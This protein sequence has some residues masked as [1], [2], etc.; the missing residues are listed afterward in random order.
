M[1]V[2]RIVKVLSLRELDT[3]LR[4]VAICQQHCLLIYYNL[5]LSVRYQQAFSDELP[6]ESEDEDVACKPCKPDRYEK[7]AAMIKSLVA[8]CLN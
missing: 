5:H 1:E 6:C 2:A 4:L 3:M 7:Y 8:A